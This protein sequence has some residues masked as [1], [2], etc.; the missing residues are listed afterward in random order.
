[1]EY[2]QSNSLSDL[3]IAKPLHDVAKLDSIA[4]IGKDDRD[5]TYLML[6]IDRISQLDKLAYFH[7]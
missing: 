1:M 3:A 7:R 2:Q 6:N 5:V 4:F